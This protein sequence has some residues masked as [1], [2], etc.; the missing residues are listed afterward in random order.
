MKP[1]T[2]FFERQI[3]KIQY[4]P[5]LSVQVRDHLFVVDY[6]TDQNSGGA[7]TIENHSEQAAAYASGLAEASGAS[8]SSVTF[9]YARTGEEVELV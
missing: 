5:D 6:K 7:H 4:A 3:A 8:V 2:L 9:V 1:Q